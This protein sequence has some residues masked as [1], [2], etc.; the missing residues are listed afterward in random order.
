MY[1]MDVYRLDGLEDFAGLGADD[2]IYGDG[3]SVIEWSEKIME[4]LPPSA[5]IIKLEPLEDGGRRITI[6]NW[7]HGGLS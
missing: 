1:H 5:I 7:P 2:M 3:I 6:S 4:A